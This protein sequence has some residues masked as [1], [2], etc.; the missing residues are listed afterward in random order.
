M[1]SN[2]STVTE[3]TGPPL[4]D[5]MLAMDVVDTLRRRER[6]VK[7]EFDET[8]RQEDLKQR[9]RKIYAAQGIDVPDHVIEQGVQ[10]LKEE[11]F[12][13]KPAPDNFNTRLAKIY[14]RRSK[15]G[16]WVLG[17]LF[18]PIIAITINYFT[19]VLPN[20]GLPDDLQDLHNEITELAKSEHALKTATQFLNAG[21]SALSNEDTDKAKAAIKEL[22]AMRTVLAQEYTIRIVNRPGVKSGVWRVP[23]I[24]TRARNYYIIVEAI[25]PSGNRINV[26]IKSEETGKTSSVDI[27]GLR[28]DE[29]VFENIASDKRDDG[30][31]ERNRFGFKERGYLK[32]SYEMPTTGG[33]ITAW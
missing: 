24:N 11:R 12:T 14:V 20:A 26:P 32:P 5:V 3:T 1:S 23:D 30:I 15:W 4:D 16:K 33:A 17:A 19:T 27:W 21:K 8:G 10:A 29:Q 18:I 31:I 2:D 28:V 22:E 9:L 6:L 25:D 13:Y 7:N